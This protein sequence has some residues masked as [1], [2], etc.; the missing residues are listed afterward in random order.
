[1]NTVKNKNVEAELVLKE[2]FGRIPAIEE[3]QIEDKSAQGFTVTLKE[4]GN[5]TVD[6]RVIFHNRREADPAHPAAASAAATA[7]DAAAP[8]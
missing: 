3:I 5:E 7:Q 4:R 2:L 1:M 6:I 8:A